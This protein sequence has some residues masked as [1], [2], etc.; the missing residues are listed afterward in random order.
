M[1]INE[2]LERVYGG[3]A[4]SYFERA[5]KA[6]LNGRRLFTVTANPE[7]IMHAGR[8]PKIHELLLSPEAEVVPDGISVVKAMG[9][10]GLP[11]SERITGVDLAA[12]L[13]KAAGENNRSVY[14]LGAKEEVVSAL[15]GK[16]RCEYPGMTVNYHN[17]YDGDKDAILRETAV[18]SP[19]L[20]LVGLGVPAQE[21]L[22]YRHLSE[23]KKGVLMGVGGS[24]DVLSGSKKRAPALFVKTNTEWLYRIACEPQRLGRFWNNNVKF[25]RE[26]RKAAK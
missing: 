13:L 21:L 14:L 10:L 4:R 11:A 8:D 17:G 19:D 20:I 22:I 24:F 12:H 15:A 18:L 16:L 25:L 7:I 5:E 9:I 3:S 6:M 23:F 2:Y 26:V 1:A